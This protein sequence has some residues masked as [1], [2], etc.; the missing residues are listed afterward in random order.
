MR[1]R[2]WLLNLDAEDELEGA[3]PYPGPFAAIIRRP[4]LLASL[5]SL[6]PAGDLVLTRSSPRAA[7]LGRVGVAWSMTTRAREALVEAGAEPAP[8]PAVH[9]LTR[10]ASR[11]LH[12][13]IGL[14]F[15]GSVFTKSADVALALL[16]SESASGWWLARRAFGFAGRGRRLVPSGAPSAADAA[17]VARAVA[18]GGVLVEPKVE[19]LA[20]HGLHG[21]LSRD[22]GIVLGQPIANVVDRAGVWREARRADGSELT[23]SERQAMEAE[24]RRAGAGLAAAGY[25]GPFG[26]DAFRHAG[27]FCPRCE[28][29]ARYSMGWGIGMGDR[30]PDLDA[31]AF[32]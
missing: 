28:I 16:R 6:V 23:V 1:P 27:G 3:R 24:A 7:A 11:A 12:A 4:A 32:A 14:P 17:F 25:F 22:G 9:V 21:F 31:I 30:R 19:V 20:D 13:E 8:A 2:A 29:N 15:P 10:V 5:A 18:L 26:I